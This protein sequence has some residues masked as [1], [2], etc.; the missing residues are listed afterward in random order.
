MKRTGFVVAVF[1]IGIIVILGGWLLGIIGR[2]DGRTLGERLDAA[3]HAY[4]PM[5][6]TKPLYIRQ[7]VGPDMGTK[8]TILWETTEFEANAVVVY[9]LKGEA[10]SEAKTLWATTDKIRENQTTRY[11]YRVDLC[12]LEPNQEYVFQ[13]GKQGHTDGEWHSF[14]THKMDKMSFL[15]TNKPQSWVIPKTS[16]SVQ[17]V[18]VKKY[19]THFCLYGPN[20]DCPDV[21]PNTL[22]CYDI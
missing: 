17:I 16:G 19:D 18:G 6:G 1:L 7:L 4:M 9:K 13:V 15:E 12:D 21:H 3:Y 14:S 2:D 10:D 5:S 8:R 11:V 22:I 20:H